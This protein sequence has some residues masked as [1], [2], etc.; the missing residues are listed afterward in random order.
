MQMHHERGMV[1]SFAVAMALF[2]VIAL[3]ASR[4]IPEPLR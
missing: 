3:W 1:V 4:A 2:A